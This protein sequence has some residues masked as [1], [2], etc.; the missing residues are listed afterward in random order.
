MSPLPMP[1]LVLSQVICKRDSRETILY[2]T[3]SIEC[4]EDSIRCV[5]PSTTFSKKR[6]TYLVNWDPSSLLTPD[7]EGQLPVH[8]AASLGC[9]EEYGDDSGNESENNRDSRGSNITHQYLERFRSVLT[10]GLT[11]FPTEL[12]VSFIPTMPVILPFDWP[13]KGLDVKLSRGSSM[14]FWVHTHYGKNNK[15]Q[16]HQ[17]YRPWYPWQAKMLST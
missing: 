7:H 10:A 12:G 16:P 5:N 2:C 13:A 17:H 9:G 6:F 4:I 14:P 8:V 3:R 11:H 15:A 1:W